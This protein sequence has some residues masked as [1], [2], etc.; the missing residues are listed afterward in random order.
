MA[1]TCGFAVLRLTPDTKPQ[2]NAGRDVSEGERTHKPM[3]TNR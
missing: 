3:R 2:V 1:V